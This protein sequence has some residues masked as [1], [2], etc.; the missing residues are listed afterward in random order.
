MIGNISSM[1]SC[2]ATDLVRSHVHH[3][4]D[5]IHDIGD[6]VV[7]GAAELRSHEFFDLFEGLL[8]QLLPS[9]AERHV[10]TFEHSWTLIPGLHKVPQDRHDPFVERHA[11]RYLGWES[12]QVV[13]HPS[14]SRGNQQLVP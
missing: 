6:D 11:G 7:V 9:G 8:V 12:V 4:V 14:R 10:R 5:D 1:V 2:P 13:L 3:V